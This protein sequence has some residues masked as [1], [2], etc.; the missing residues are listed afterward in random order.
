MTAPSSGSKKK[1]AFDVPTEEAP[2]AGDVI[3]L[4]V[5]SRSTVSSMRASIARFR[6][7]VFQKSILIKDAALTRV[8]KPEYTFGIPYLRKNMKSAVMDPCIYLKAMGEV[9]GIALVVGWIIT[10][11]FR[12]EVI[13]SNPIKDRLG[14]NNL[15]VGWDQPP[16]SYVSMF[17]VTLVTYFGLR[18]CFT[19]IMKYDLMLENRL[20]RKRKHF[21]VSLAT[22]LYG[23]GVTSIPIILVCRPTENVWLHS[24]IFLYGI[25]CLFFVVAA[26]FWT[27]KGS[28]EPLANKIFFGV[29]SINAIT[30][31]IMVIYSYVLY[32]RVGERAPGKGFLP[33]WLVQSQ[34]LSWFICNALTAKFLP[35]EVLISRKIALVRGVE[36]QKEEQE[37]DGPSLLSFKD[38]P[39]LSS[40][41]DLSLLSFH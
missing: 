37:Q 6:G 4:S 12:R 15:C 9:L 38:N 39:S 23:I 1:V 5:T 19:S 30:F 41:D 7:S 34:D 14:Y 2:L 18:F 29:Y 32:D 28:L 11:I 36:E 3:D 33:V 20:I 26:S 35:N 8:R 24:L 13:E 25:V 31:P 16:A 27:S 17:F 21:F 22:Y 10:G 40:Q